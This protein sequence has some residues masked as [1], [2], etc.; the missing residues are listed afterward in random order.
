MP[1]APTAVFEE[2]MENSEPA[3]QFLDYFFLKT[4]FISIKGKIKKKDR[5][6][7][8]TEMEFSQQ[9]IPLD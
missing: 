9:N 4:F 1:F 7:A 8:I 5:A 6:Q 3:F 2:K